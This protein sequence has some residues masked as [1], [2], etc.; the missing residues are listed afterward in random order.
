MQMVEK[1]LWALHGCK[2]GPPTDDEG[3]LERQRQVK[4]LPLI[5]TSLQIMKGPYQCTYTV[6]AILFCDGK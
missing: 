1:Y 6:C 5:S 2:P 3:R 4:T